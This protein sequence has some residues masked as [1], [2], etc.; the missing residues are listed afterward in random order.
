MYGRLPK[1]LIIMRFLVGNRYLYSYKNRIND[2]SKIDRCRNIGNYFFRAFPPRQGDRGGK[3][4]PQLY[5]NVK[6]E[7]II[8]LK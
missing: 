3:V 1:L 4:G 5:Q 6:W 8:R 2:M 7:L